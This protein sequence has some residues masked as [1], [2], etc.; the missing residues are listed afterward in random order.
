MDEKIYIVSND[1]TK[2]EYTYSDVSNMLLSGGFMS[3]F[4]KLKVGEKMYYNELRL[5]FERIK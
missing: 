2:T 3:V 4:D 1:K 5:E